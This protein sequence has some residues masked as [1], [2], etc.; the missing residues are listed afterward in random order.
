[1]YPSAIAQS[2]RP[3]FIANVS[4]PWASRICGIAWAGAAGDRARAGTSGGIDARSRPRQSALAPR[5]L[6]SHLSPQTFNAGLPL[7]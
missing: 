6:P 1:M 2:V 5:A 7:L 3:M 4:Y